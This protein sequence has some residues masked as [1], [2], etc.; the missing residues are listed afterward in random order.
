M[1]IIHRSEL[2]R[3]FYDDLIDDYRS[4][5]DGF[6][7]RVL[8]YDDLMEL[9]FLRGSVHMSKDARKLLPF[10]DLSL[11]NFYGIDISG[12]DF[13]NTNADINPQTVY[14][15][16]LRGC[17]FDGLDMSGKCFDGC[18]IRGTSFVGTICEIDPSK[19]I[20]FDDACFEGSRYKSR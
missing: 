19:V 15:K 20:G 5:P 1:A 16:N 6:T 13:S 11:V 4:N 10:I 9:I 18:D 12:I 7:R 17:C 8:E 14:K 2:L 3:K